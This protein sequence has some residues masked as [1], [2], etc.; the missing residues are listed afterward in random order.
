M[1]L[2]CENLSIQHGALTV[3]SDVC[4]RLRP[5]QITGVIGPNGVGKSSLLRALAGLAPCHG[6]VRFDG[7]PA[8]PKDQRQRVAYMPQDTSASASLSLIE[9]VLL[10]R[11]GS[12]GM[13]VP[14]GLVAEA[15]A[16]LDSFGLTALS[17]R[18]LDAVSGGQRQLTYLA[19]ALFRAPRVLM[20]DE[21]TAA[22]DLRH[23]LV[24]L[25]KLRD[26]AQDDTIAVVIAIHDLSLAAQF[27]DQLVCLSQGRVDASGT[28]AQVLTARRMRQVYGVEAQIHQ[29]AGQS[30]RIE[31]LRAV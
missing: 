15:E 6:T 10:G 9:V 2:S 29:G 28:P 7:Q 1:S 23:Q 11:L 19:Q 4:L 20:L 5:G 31:T 18:T 16:T 8:L 3:L 12:L 14:A 30:L 22:L 26:L 24:V 21:P 13:R 25:E 17:H 27:C